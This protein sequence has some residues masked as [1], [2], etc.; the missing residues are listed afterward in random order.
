MMVEDQFKDFLK[1]IEDKVE[2][3]PV[4]LLEGKILE[5]RDRAL[6]VHQLK[7]ELK[8]VQFE[9]LNVGQSPLE[10]EI[11]DLGV[12]NLRGGDAYP[13]FKLF[14][15]FPKGLAPFD[16]RTMAKEQ[17]PSSDPNRV[18]PQ[19]F[20]FKKAAEFS[21]LSQTQSRPWSDGYLRL[22]H[23]KGVLQKR[24][25]SASIFSTKVQIIAHARALKHD[26]QG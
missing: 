9:D 12:T 15:A 23:P 20:C 4:V 2:Q 5:G 22:P 8:T 16:A 14:V 11:P 6:A 25:N 7:R 10:Y 19:A 24:S 18:H 17:P 1:D 3:R 21:D 26:A 13:P